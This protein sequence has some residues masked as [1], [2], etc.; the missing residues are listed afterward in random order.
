MSDPF[1]PSDIDPNH[2]SVPIP[3]LE[4][5]VTVASPG[6]FSG[7]KLLVDGKAA[8]KVSIL[9]AKYKLPD[10]RVAE[11]S[12]AFT[13]TSPTVTV[14]GKAYP[15]GEAVPIPFLVLQFLPLGL[16]GLGGLLGGLAGGL[17]WSVNLVIYRTEWPTPA[18]AAAMVV[19]AGASF[20]GWLVLATLFA[21]GFQS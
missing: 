15:T 6:M 10:D 5:R 21:L 12:G 17:G 9:G 2:H 8:P 7:L 13:R 16:V 20:G 11:L 14:D 3:G 1:A 19:V 4:G 18:K